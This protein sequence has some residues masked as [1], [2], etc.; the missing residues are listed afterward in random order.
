MIEIG[1]FVLFLILFFA[2]F[3]LFGLWQ[4]AAEENKYWQEYYQLDQQQKEEE[5]NG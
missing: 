3:L 5:D 1:V 2:N 4:E